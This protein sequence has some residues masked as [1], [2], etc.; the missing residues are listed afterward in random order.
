MRWDYECHGFSPITRDAYSDPYL[1]EHASWLKIR[2]RDYSQ[3]AGREELFER[4]GAILISKF[5]TDALWHATA[6]R[7]DPEDCQLITG[8]VD[9]ESRRVPRARSKRSGIC[10][11][12]LRR[13][14]LCKNDH[15]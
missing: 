4:A 13:G 14:D 3:W 9:P 7:C 5:G 12:A 1:L 10:Y 8:K 15:S 11:R 6:P 2:H